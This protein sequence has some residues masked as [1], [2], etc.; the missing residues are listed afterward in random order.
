[1]NYTLILLTMMLTNP[2][3]LQNGY[4]VDRFPTSGGELAITF[5]G[6]GTLMFNWN[7]KVIHVDPVTR[8][9]DYSNLP[10][11]DLILVTHEHTDH[12]DPEA[13]QQLQKENTLVVLTKTCLDK[14]GSSPEIKTH[15]M[16]NGDHF[17]LGEIK[18]D[19]IPAYNMTHKRPG[20]GYYHP[21]G[22]GNGYVIGFGDKRVLVAGDTE[23]IPE[24]KALKDIDIAFLPM[25]LPYTMTPEMVAD[26]AA[27]FKPDVLYPYH[28]GSSDT[29]ELLRLMKDVQGVEVRIRKME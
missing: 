14:L 23:N 20:G 19:A 21:K 27:A 8:E 25:N 10:K 17:V 5:I 4:E 22:S 2:A 6:H 24:V 11:A 18:I 26:A 13:I 28:Y 7:G 3:N 16:A 1:M 9:A 29:G 15:V 12:L